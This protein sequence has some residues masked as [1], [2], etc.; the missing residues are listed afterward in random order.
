MQSKIGEWSNLNFEMTRVE[1]LCEFSQLMKP[2]VDGTLERPVPCVELSELTP[3]I[4]P[5]AR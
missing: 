1:I 4:Y 3:G 2:T 5:N